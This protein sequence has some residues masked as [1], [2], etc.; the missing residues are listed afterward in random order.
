[1]VRI[2][3]IVRLNATM[4]TAH[5]AITRMLSQRPSSTAGN[6]E[7]ALSQSK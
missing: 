4:R 2:T 1:M 5:S 6:D 3:A 7:T